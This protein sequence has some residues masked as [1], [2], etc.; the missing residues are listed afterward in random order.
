MSV[1]TDWL[2]RVRDAS[3]R[4]E[5]LTRELAALEDARAKCVP[6]RTKGSGVSVA[7]GGLHSDPTQRD[8]FAREG[9]EER[10]EVTR[11]ALDEC[12]SI[13]G[14]CL[15]LL[16]SV[17]R[18]VSQR[19]S[20]ALEIYYID[21]AATWSEVARE[22]GCAR[23]SVGFLRDQALTWLNFVGIEYAIDSA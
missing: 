4:I 19:A 20:L 9:L 6:W 18:H 15:R 5:W 23:S 17:S 8:A 14:D 22:M 16:D 3:G 7:S 1:A 2:D 10:I 11:H 21:R 13:V 12:Q